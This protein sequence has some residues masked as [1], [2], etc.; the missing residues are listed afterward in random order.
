MCPQIHNIADAILDFTLAII[1]FIFEQIS[2]K[3]GCERKLLVGL[4]DEKIPENTLILGLTHSFA[5]LIILFI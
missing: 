2:G 1:L 5:R 4:I 3:A